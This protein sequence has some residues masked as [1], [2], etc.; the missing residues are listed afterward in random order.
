MGV[1][2][3]TRN[4]V[5]VLPQGAL[6]QK[7]K[8]GRPL[9]IKLGIDPTS[10]DLHLGFAYALENLRAF[11][12]EGHEIVLI[13]GDYTARIGDPSG[14][15]AERPVLAGEVLDANAKEFEQQAYRI[16]DP[17]RTTVRFN[18]EWLGKLTYEE[19]V[20]LCRTMTVARLLERDDF[21][22]R[23]AAHAPIS[24]SELLYPLMQAYD[25]VA[26]EADIEVG[27]TD[28]LY[29]LLA[30]RDVMTHYGLDPQAVITYPLLI[31]LDGEEKMSKSKGNYVAVQ[32]PPEEMFG[33]VMSIPDKLL[34]QWWV[35][36]LGR[37]APQ[38]D[39]MA[40]KLA[41]G[42]GIVEKWHGTEAAAAAEAHFTR[43]VRRHEVPEDAPEVEL[44]AGDPIHLPALLVEELG[45]GST[46]EARRLIAQGGVKID[47]EAATEV[48][49]PRARLEGATLQAGKRRFARFRA[50]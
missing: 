38:T 18:G 44:P 37:E 34:E 20:R 26:I 41:L 50:A 7:L 6:E 47:G 30:G 48:D 32:D 28:Q 3:L 11:Q 21:A 16:I 19:T 2:E 29:N 25:S 14:R 8:L 15:S 5:D 12:E 24:L 40:S 23:F 10:P 31:G 35:I 22:K 1:D 45:V 27:G 49:V 13:V 39:P 33:K 4:A 46:S 42:G 36:C 9:R 17:E 43:V